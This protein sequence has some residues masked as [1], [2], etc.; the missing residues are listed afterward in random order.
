[1]G[2]YC[3]GY[4]YVYVYLGPHPGALQSSQEAAQRYRGVPLWR[5]V[6]T[7]TSGSCGYNWL[8]HVILRLEGQQGGGAINWHHPLLR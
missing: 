8:T 4:V 2:L 1:M 7:Q 5:V 3:Y 6:M